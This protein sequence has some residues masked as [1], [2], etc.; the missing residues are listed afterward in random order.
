MDN[1][2]KNYKIYFTSGLENPT[3]EI[4]KILKKNGLEETFDDLIKKRKENKTAGI[5]F[6]YSSTKRL[7][8]A[9]LDEKSFILSAQKELGANQGVAEN[10]YKDVKTLIL[11]YTIKEEI[12]QSR[13]KEPNEN[14]ILMPKIKAPI[15]V[16]KILEERREN[17]LKGKATGP[18]KT[19]P[20]EEKII[21]PAPT[22]TK[23][24]VGQKKE[25]VS[26]KETENPIVKENKGPDTYREPIG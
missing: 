24:S 3:D 1:L 5:D 21:E 10:L 25:I 19:E 26:K 23:K 13:E 14:S 17:V 18:I 15:E 20:I 2:N 9:E 4:M 6:L 22:K 7:A 12:G 16:E 11:P 8:L